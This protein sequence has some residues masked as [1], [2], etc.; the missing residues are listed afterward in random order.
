MS[1]DPQV[2]TFLDQVAA[3]NLPPFNEMSV[4]EARRAAVALSEV[5]GAPE[6]VASVDNLAIPGPAGEIPVRV[7]TPEQSGPLPV[8]VY[9]HGGGW[10][11]GDLETHD[12]LCR[13]LANAAG[14]VVASVDYRLAPEHKFPAAAE[15]AYAATRWVA[16]NAGQIGVDPQHI[17]VGGDSAGGNLAAVVALMARDRG[18]PPLVFQLLI[19]PATDSA[20]DTASC[21]ENAEGYLLTLEALRWFW[22]HYLS[23][24]A[25]RE[26][27]YAAPL[28]A[29]NV[30]GLPPALV[31]TAEFD[32]LRDE[33]EVYAARL[34][35]AGVPVQ[36]KRYDGM[37][38]GFFG[39]GA[40]VDQARTAM[41]E[42]AASLQAA[43]AAPEAASAAPA[44]PGRG[45]GLKK[46]FDSF[47]SSR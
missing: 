21:R 8:L 4:E 2:Q 42:V 16:E 25:D 20:C 36:L 30:R 12:A 7:Y 40:M 35:D 17:A 46:L 32:P 19:Y 33:G 10:V 3:L 39:M 37:I 28:R 11:I 43:F 14:C 38:H 23:G 5:Q 22:N 45:K 44:R 9:F 24:E 41:E 31:L 26:N 1:L 29:P 15:D 47:R 6:P 18:G 27:P 13:T 34:R